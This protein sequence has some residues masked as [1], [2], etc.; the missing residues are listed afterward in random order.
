MSMKLVAAEL[1][2]RFNSF[3]SCTERMK[4][5]KAVITAPEIFRFFYIKI[6]SAMTPDDTTKVY[7]ETSFHQ[8]WTHTCTPPQGWP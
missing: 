5:D 8:F 6:E 3:V 1:K 7:F 4:A 2:I